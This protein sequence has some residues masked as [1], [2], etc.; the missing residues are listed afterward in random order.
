VCEKKKPLK[1][2]IK[3]LVVGS[4]LIKRKVGSRRWAQSPKLSN[5]WTCQGMWKVE[6][7]F[8]DQGYGA[9]AIKVVANR[10]VTMV[11]K[12]TKVP[13]AWHFEDH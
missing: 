6:Q 5:H 3:T 1:R 2:W 10:S 9:Q 12:V 13:L 11:I 4:K 7:E 8:N